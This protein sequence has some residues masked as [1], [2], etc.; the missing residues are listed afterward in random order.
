MIGVTTRPC[1]DKPG[2]PTLNTCTRAADDG[3]GES[4]ESDAVEEAIWLPSAECSDGPSIHRDAPRTAQGTTGAGAAAIAC[5]IADAAEAAASLCT[6]SCERRP[7]C[8]CLWPPCSSCCSSQLATSYSL[9]NPI[10]S[11]ASLNAVTTS[12]VSSGS[13]LPPG[14]A[15]SPA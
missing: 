8:T 6:C 14:R 9:G 3:V 5:D 4:E 2:A 1:F 11:S 10:S 15:T 7:S 13:R 12:D